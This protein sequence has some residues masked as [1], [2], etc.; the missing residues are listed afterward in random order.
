ME[1]TSRIRTGLANDRE[2][3]E[4]LT[5]GATI[6]HGISKAGNVIAR[7]VPLWRTGE[8][9]FRITPDYSGGGRSRLRGYQTRCFKSPRSFV[10]KWASLIGCHQMLEVEK[11]NFD[12]PLE[13][14]R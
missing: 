9:S 5:S 6:W 3:L 14:V 7:V 8:L 10:A 2:A 11:I 12:M 13:V 4:K 1:R